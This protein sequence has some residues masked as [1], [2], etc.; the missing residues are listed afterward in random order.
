M[1]IPAH[2]PTQSFCFLFHL[3]LLLYDSI[4]IPEQNKEEKQQKYVA[5]VDFPFISEE[6]PGRKWPRFLLLDFEHSHL[7]KL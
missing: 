1:M 5:P 7:L 2:G 6:D 3:S 4:N